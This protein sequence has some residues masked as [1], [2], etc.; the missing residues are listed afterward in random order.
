MRDSEQ[1]SFL[2]ECLHHNLYLSS[3]DVSIG[4]WWI[5]W[6]IALSS[7]QFKSIRFLDT[8]LRDGEQTPGASLTVEKKLRIARKLDELG[9]DV[10]EAGS[11][12]ASEGEI[13]AIQLI[14]KDKPRAE[15]MSFARSLK[16]DIDAAQ[17]SDAQSVH[18]VVPTSPIHLKY[19]LKKT[20]DEVVAMAVDAVEY[21]KECGLIV[22]LSS[23][24]ATRSDLS[25]LKRVFKAGI[26]AGADRLCACDTVGV[27]T[28]ERSRA[29]YGELST[30][31][32]I[33]L[34]VHCHNDFGMAVANSVEGLRAGASQVH[35][36]VNGVGERA[37]N[38]SLEE[39]VMVLTSLYD[40]KT[41]IQTKLLYGTSK[42]VSSLMG[43]TVQP[44]K[45]IVGD[46]AFT[47]LSGIHSHGV[48]AN[49][50]TYEPIPP[51]LVGA[52]RKFAAG[53]L[54]GQHG[55]RA[56][57]AELELKPTDEQS[58]DISQRVKALGDRGKTLTDVDL[59]SIAEMVMGLP[60]VRPVKLE[61][62]TVMT[63][64]RITPTAAVRIQ[65]DGQLIT[66]A[67]TGIGPVDAAINAIKKAM[68]QTPDISLLEYNVKAITGGTNALVE[69]SA[70]LQKGETRVS[71]TGSHADIVMASVEALLGGMNILMAGTV[72][73]K[74][75][76]VNKIAE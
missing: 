51:Q 57:L 41:S 75:G 32:K 12:I 15:I 72:R 28:P 69:V 33:P 34:S 71:S 44:N 13:K 55:I 7:G 43:L 66:E 42:L 49:P 30:Y 5:Q 27:L 58:R 62:L 74:N 63:G 17:K 59:Y 73:K 60:V 19:K 52:R 3:H 70:T 8:T 46:N 54:S 65:V 11:A 53:K 22:E 6:G 31:F 25:F 38:A 67:A 35:V 45:A 36:T 64:N 40:V 9:V 1:N 21:A 47:H 48:A 61:E 14:V 23:E 2:E 29:F 39:V 26:E 50:I 37:G 24:D 20:E 56:F 18:L 10:I 4:Y 68:A 76:E 16:I